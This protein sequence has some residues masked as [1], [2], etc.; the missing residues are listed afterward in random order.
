MF[1]KIL[2]ATD[3]SE[4]SNRAAEMG[5]GL[6]KLSGGK[7]TALYVAQR[8]S[9][10]IG[11][12]TGDKLDEVVTGMW[13]A[14]REEGDKATKQVEEMASKSGVSVEKRVVEGHP[15]SEILGMAEET[16]MDIIVMGAIGKTGLTKFLL[17]SVAE[18]VV[19]NSKVP[20]IIVPMDSGK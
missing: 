13:R 3:G 7:V 10:P 6:A 8:K 17:G 2:V 1:E 11:G 15:A 5:I 9:A 14:V 20:V 16:P 12:L 18:K 4:C 19:R